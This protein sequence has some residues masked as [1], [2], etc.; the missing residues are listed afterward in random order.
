ME[1]LFYSLD[2]KRVYVVAFGKYQ[3]IDPESIAAI[4]KH[5]KLIF[6]ISEKQASELVFQME[7]D[8]MLGGKRISTCFDFD[9][10]DEWEHSKR[11]ISDSVGYID[12]HEQ[13][14]GVI[15]R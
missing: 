14:I 13:V 4:T 3:V 10:S 15:G 9:L 1:Q 7:D 6:P 11:R 2:K 8:V 5:I 12:Y